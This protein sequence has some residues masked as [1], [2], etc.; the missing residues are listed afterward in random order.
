MEYKIIA[1][2]SA[3][4]LEIDGASYGTVPMKIITDDK[5]YVDDCNLNVCEMI[6]DLSKYKGK[7]QSSCPNVNEW[8]KA[9]E[10]AKKVICITISSALS[11]SYNS[12][13]LALEDYIKNN[14]DREGF[15]IDTLS[16]GP[17]IL[18]IIEKLIEF[19]S[20]KL[21]IEEIKKRIE[22]Y[23]KKTHLLF[24]LES[25][26]N[27][28]NNGR[29]SQASAKVAGILGIRAVGKASNEGTLEMVSKARGEKN[30]IGEL[31]KAMIDNGFNGGKVKIHHCE[32]SKAAA[33]L[34]E[35]IREMFP[36]SE[37]E[38][39]ETRALCSFYAESGG[40]IVGY[41]G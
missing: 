36:K 9:F 7:S 39:N 11:G 13:C 3:D 41:E 8:K 28:A 15:V 32:N 2:S 10:G 33:K 14:P 26:K 38:I 37:I 31:I 25:M 40:L 34:F 24:C 20:E 4:I 6:S 1:D 18:L 21:S 22:E 27:L 30:S 16:A 19:I 17:E 35:K 12:A 23:K 29:I 5:E